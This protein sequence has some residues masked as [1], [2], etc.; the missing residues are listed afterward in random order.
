MFA[1]TL[2]LLGSACAQTRGIVPTDGELRSTLHPGQTVYVLL[3]DGRSY[4][5]TVSSI[6]DTHLWVEVGAD[7]T[8][9]PLNDIRYVEH[10]L[11]RAQPATERALAGLTVLLGLV[12]VLAVIALTAM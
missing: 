12:A 9:V 4:T 1:A 2:G 5:G 11:L 6:D 7:E 3:H 8:G 10:K